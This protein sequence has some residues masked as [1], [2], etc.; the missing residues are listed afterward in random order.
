M[1]SDCYL[2]SEDEILLKNVWL[3]LVLVGYVPDLSWPDHW[4]KLIQKIACH[5]RELGREPS[6][7][8]GYSIRSGLDSIMKS[9][10]NNIDRLSENYCSSS[11][12]LNS[13]Q[14]LYLIAL[15]CKFLEQ[16]TLGMF[17]Q[18]YQMMTEDFVVKYEFFKPMELMILEVLSTVRTI[19]FLRNNAS[20]LEAEFIDL[21]DFACSNIP[22]AS[23]FGLNRLYDLLR[24]SPNLSLSLK[25][26]LSQFTRLT[27]L[28]E[29]I[30]CGT[31]EIPLS[32]TTEFWGVLRTPGYEK[33]LFIELKS[34]LKVFISMGISIYPS[35]PF[36]FLHHI[37]NMTILKELPIGY[38]ISFTLIVEFISTLNAQNSVKTLLLCSNTLNSIQRS[39]NR[40]QNIKNEIQSKH[41]CFFADNEYYFGI[42][43]KLLENLENLTEG[44]EKAQ[45]DPLYKKMTSIPSRITAK[46]PLSSEYLEFA[47]I[48]DFVASVFCFGYFLNKS[49]VATTI[50][51][52]LLTFLKSAA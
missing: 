18:M 8:P 40:I 13:A 45:H 49:Q 46:L 26:A 11:R 3:V 25:C 20:I 47:L 34:F 9:Q 43:T 21:V 30:Q 17:K 4:R 12:P 38:S 52:R 24:L 5:S 29:V 16:Y 19:E 44:P 48:L 2:I 33:S 41:L 23:K 51:L 1:T 37:K 39:Y 10:S 14:K 42:F 22:Q 15:K 28:S 27:E 7:E 35:I 31:M 50:C 36:V 32:D 6:L